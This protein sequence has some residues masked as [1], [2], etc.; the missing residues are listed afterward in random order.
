LCKYIYD[1][2][3]ITL[4]PFCPYIDSVICTYSTI[5]AED[6]KDT[7]GIRPPRNRTEAE[8]LEK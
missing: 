8:G 1:I 5:N 7:K 4:P 6:G 2:D 3:F